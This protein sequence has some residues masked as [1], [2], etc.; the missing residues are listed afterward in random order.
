[1]VMTLIRMSRGPSTLD[2]VVA[3]TGRIITPVPKLV[4][5][6]LETSSIRRINVEP[7]QTVLFL[8]RYLG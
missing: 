2:R 3:A 1:M 8:H 5:Q 4:V 7:G 6:P